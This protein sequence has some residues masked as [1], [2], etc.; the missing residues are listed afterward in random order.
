[1]T[2]RLTIT[3]CTMLFPA[4]TLVL[5]VDAPFDVPWIGYDTAVYPE[6][7]FPVASHSADF[8]SDGI[9][10]L[11]TVS[12]GGTPWLS[13][14]FGD[15]DGGYLPPTTYPLLIESADLAVADFDDDKDLDIVTADTGRFLE[16]VSVSL[17][18]N[19]GTG[20]FS[21]A[22]WFAMGNHGPYGITT[23]DFDGDGWP[24][25]ATANEAYIECN[26]TVSVLLNDGGS[27]FIAPHVYSISTCTHEIDSGDLDGDGAPELVIA[28][29]TNKFTIMTNDGAGSFSPQ[30][31]LTG[32][33]AGSIPQ[34]P[35]AHIA[36]IDLDGDNDLFFSNRDS[37]GVNNGA[38]GLCATT[39]PARSP[40]LKSCRS[41][42]TAAAPSTSTPRTSPATGGPTSSA[43]PG[44]AGSCSKATARADSAILE[45]SGRDMRLRSS[46]RPISIW[47]ATST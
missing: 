34:S 3:L 2:R 24:D 45:G 28:H 12:F 16:G 7:I 10:D 37:G 36:D 13:V 43:P 30:P 39:A 23:G 26:N 14:L 4:P 46:R 25:V 42:G 1:M 47:M 29:N 44:A 22:G 38:L 8:N 19:D 15:G 11:V 18:E 27:G 17:Y 6:G 9:P 33:V 35:T 20:S 31:P 41:T 5:A 40:L 32:I 21:F